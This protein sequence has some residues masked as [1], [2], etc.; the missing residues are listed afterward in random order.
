MSENSTSAHGGHGSFPED[1]GGFDVGWRMVNVYAVASIVG[2]SL[3]FALFYYSFILIGVGGGSL[4]VGVA[5]A[6]SYSVAYVAFAFVSNL[7]QK[8]R[9]IASASVGVVAILCAVRSVIAGGMSWVF[10]V[11]ACALSAG[12]ALAILMWFETLCALSGKN[13]RI[14]VVASFALASGFCAVLDAFD[15]GLGL[16]ANLF[17]ASFLL[18]FSAAVY[19]ACVVSSPL[20]DYLPF[21]VAR[22]SDSRSC[23]TVNSAMLTAVNSIAQ[24]FSLCVLCLSEFRSEAVLLFLLAGSFVVFVVLGIDS[25]KS[26]RV[27]ESLFRHLMLPVMAACLLLMLFVPENMWVWFCVGILL[28]SFLPYTSAITATCEHVVR[29]SLSFV[30]AG[31]FVRALS[32][33]GILLGFGIGWV[34]FSSDWFDGKEFMACVVILTLLLIVST[35]ALDKGDLYPKDAPSSFHDY[36]DGSGRGQWKH[37]CELLAERS[38]LTARETE[39]MLLLAKGYTAELIQ[40]RLYI[41]KNTVKTHTYNLY[42]KIG[43]HSKTELLQMIES[44][45]P[46]TN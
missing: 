17:F 4:A 15:F 6:L 38:G 5:V 13:V 35:M 8:Q 44:I 11:V 7:I 16:G 24:G 39:I 10:L 26:F 28:F 3:S 43:V 25:A 1:A 12:N 32:M 22:E 19:I 30:R 46:D 45:D 2:S 21:V 42:G 31:G 33:G 20:C 18:L 23:I 36:G 41:S 29:N 14:A 40:E 37:R 34:A 27:N 9:R